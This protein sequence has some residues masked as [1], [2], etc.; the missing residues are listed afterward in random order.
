M[1]EESKYW[2]DATKEHFNKELVMTKKD[3]KDL[4]TLLNFGFMIL[5]MFLVRPK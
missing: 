4:R 5:L 3:D 2:S 1:T